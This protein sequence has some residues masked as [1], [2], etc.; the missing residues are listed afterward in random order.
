MWPLVVGLATATAA[1]QSAAEPMT[2]SRALRQPEAWFRTG[3]ARI[4]L[5][6]VVANQTPAGSWPKNV[7]TL[8]SLAG[9]KTSDLRGTFDNG[10][11]TGELR[12]LAR[13]FSVTSETRYRDAFLAGLDSI[14]AAQYPSGG[15]PQ[16]H[17][18]PT[19]SYHRHITFNDDTMLRL[20][21]L[22]REVEREPRY[23]FVPEERRERAKR[24]VR[25][26]IDC[27]VK[28]QIRVAG[29]LAVWCAQ[30]DAETLEPRA[31]RAFELAS[32]SG[33]ESAGV[34]RFL[35]ALEDPPPDVV[36]AVHAGARW[37]DQAKLTGVRVV[38][39]DGDR[40]LVAD[41]MAPPLWA[42]FYDLETGRPFYCGRDGV[43]RSDLSE[44]EAERRNGYAWLGPWGEDVARRYAVWQ[45]KFP[46]HSTDKP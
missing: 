31:A 17:P 33:A 38:K 45:T 37:F 34:L 16:F 35:M 43:K 13:A 5:D 4:A 19:N 9:G 7:D 41:P 28:C 18:P 36:R 10:A 15:W 22:L 8:S 44:I 20:L 29:R 46:E 23:R 14:L 30:H 2:M 27:I 21:E 32:L 25:R 6:H 3:E 39:V 40:R 11:T 24:A 42:R 12:L 1:A 26:G